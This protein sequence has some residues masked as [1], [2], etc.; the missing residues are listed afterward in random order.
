MMKSDKLLLIGLVSVIVPMLFYWKLANMLVISSETLGVLELASYTSLALVFAGLSAISY[1]MWQLIT[2]HN[3]KTKGML[4]AVSHVLSQASYKRLFLILTLAYGLL[5]TILSGIFVF[6]PDVNFSQEF[7]V[8]IPSAAIVACCDTPA[9]LPRLVIYLTEHVGLLIYPLNLMF[10]FAVSL[11]VGLNMTLA[12]VSL[13]TSSIGK[14]NSAYSL[15]GGSA[16]L[17]AACPACAAP[18]LY[19]AISGIGT[20][21]AITAASFLQVFFV[22]S[23]VPILLVLTLVNSRRLVE[24]FNSISC[25]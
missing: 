16:G 2:K 18:V 4:S 22:L 10:L 20:V 6:N 8:A 17:L 14:K 25:S 24:M 11:L 13:R 1:S 12:V 5:Y 3:S 23:I 21:T 15:F 9:Q 7:P 19:S